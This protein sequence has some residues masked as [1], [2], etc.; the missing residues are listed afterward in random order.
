MYRGYELHDRNDGKFQTSK[1]RP[2]DDAEYYWALTN[3][4]LHWNII[5]KGKNRYEWAGTF[6]QIVDELE[7]YNSKISARIIHN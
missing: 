6:E 2:Y 1:A 7:N 4:K 3:D 5:Y